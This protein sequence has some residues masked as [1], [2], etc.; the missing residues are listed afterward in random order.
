MLLAAIGATRDERLHEVALMRVL[1]AR[2]RQVAAAQWS[3][4]ALLGA[5]T[6][7]V[8]AIASEILAAQFAQRVLQ[9]EPSAHWGPAFAGAALGALAI[10]VTG[11]LATRG[12]LRTSPATT[13]RAIAG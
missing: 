2:A 9:I 7:L 1:G 4:F 13:L 5:L 10:A 8:A 3:E 12:V 11:A 6:A